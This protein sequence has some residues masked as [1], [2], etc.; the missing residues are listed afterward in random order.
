M[1]GITQHK[2]DNHPQQPYTCH[3]KLIMCC[4]SDTTQTWCCCLI[5]KVSLLLSFQRNCL[6][7]T[8]TFCLITFVPGLLETNFSFNWK[9]K[10]QGLY[11][12]APLKDFMGAMVCPWAL[13]WWPLLQ[14]I[15]SNQKWTPQSYCFSCITCLGVDYSVIITKKQYLLTIGRKLVPIGIQLLA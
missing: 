8:C 7:G 4:W 14:A 1:H 15:F 3:G 6:E 10:V 5:Y 11:S 2:R 9:L 12:G 13:G